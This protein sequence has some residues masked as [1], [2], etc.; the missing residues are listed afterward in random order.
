[1][2]LATVGEDGHPS[3]RIVLLKAVTDGDF[4]FFTDYRSRKGRE[5]DRTP[6]AALVFWWHPLARQVRVTGTVVRTTAAESDGY[7]L[8][9]PEG[10]R[11][12][13]W[14]SEQSS[15]IADREVLEARVSAASERFGG[16][17]IPRPSHWGGYRLTPREVEFW[18]GRTSRLHD[19]FLYTRT[20]E[21]RWHRARLSP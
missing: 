10:S 15:E 1:M 12:G 16:G 18:Q 17:T 2:T 7:F 6:E 19:R 13:A 9:R 4:V 21:H 14:A 5:L 11:L 20:P 3:A 8:T